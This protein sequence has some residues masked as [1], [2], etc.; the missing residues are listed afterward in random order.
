MFVSALVALVL[1]PRQAH[2]TARMLAPVPG[3]YPDTAALLRRADTTDSA[4]HRASVALDRARARAGRLAA[5]D[6]LPAPL[7]ARRDSL[8][9]AS[10]ELARALNRAELSPLPASYRALAATR[11]LK[12]DPRIGTLLDSLTDVQRSREAFAAGETGGVDPIFVALTA[13]VNAIGRAIAAIAD[14]RRDAINA[15]LAV[16]G[17]AAPE[18]RAIAAETTQARAQL[19]SAQR[20][21]SIGRVTLV[22]ARRSVSALNQRAD[23]AR[24]LANV[25]APPIALLAA[26][27]VLGAAVGFAVT[28]GSELA[29]PRVADGGEAGRVAGVR[30]LAVLAPPTPDPERMRRS[31]DRTQ[32]PLIDATSSE[33]RLLYLELAGG[34]AST[35]A[36]GTAPIP[37]V[38]VTGDESEVVATVAANLAVA[39][40]LD[41]RSTLL[42]DADPRVAAVSGIFGVRLAP[43]VSDVLA[44][45]VTWPESITTATVGRERVVD[46]IPAGGDGRAVW[47][48]D[49]SGT[50]GGPVTHEAL[51]LELSRLARRY[52]L[53]VVAAP[54][55]LAR[56][57]PDSVLPG[58]DV[59]FTARVAYTTLARLSAAVETLRVSGMR[60][61]GLVLWN[62]DA[63]PVTP[64]RRDV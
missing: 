55:G 25:S 8:S 22:A 35:G 19:D 39:G 54:A 49:R 21:D 42:V 37:M 43:G 64:R 2:R 45:G 3:D 47:P 34:P 62:A 40:A 23:H 5:L 14:A 52:D 36:A 15:Q 6:T 58:P 59:V 38:T 20:A 1:I 48:A 50:A 53:V 41:S 33:Y 28:F 18:T 9:A 12:G 61:R 24:D 30:T 51:R 10:A 17:G 11:T 27:L 16:L 29:R 4:V 13:R 26:A 7:A 56:V 31:T 60:V 46:I 57:G 32:S 63:A 44:G